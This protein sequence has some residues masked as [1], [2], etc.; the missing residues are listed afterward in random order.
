MRR[1]VSIVLAVMLILSI[2]V[3][4]NAESGL[5]YQGSITIAWQA[6]TD[7]ENVA[8]AKEEW[9][10]L[11]PGITI[12]FIDMM[13]NSD[14]T[15]WL[16][17]K[18]AGGMAPDIFWAQWSVVDAGIYPNGCAVS[19][20][21]YM[22]KPNIYVEGNEKWADLFYPSLYA[23]TSGATGNQ[24]CVVMDYVGTA[25]YYNK[26]MFEAAGINMA[27]YHEV[28]TWSDYLDICQ[29]LKD[30]GYTAWS[31]GFGNDTT[32]TL[33]TWLQR[34]ILTNLYADI[35]DDVCVTNHVQP[36]NVDNYIA[37]R[38]GLIGPESER[39]MS[40]WENMKYMVDNYMP[41]DCI[42]AACTFDSIFSQF[43]TGQLAMHWNSTGGPNSYAAANIDFEVGSFNFPVPDPD[44]FKYATDFD[45]SPA[46]GGPT[47]TYTYAISSKTAN[48]SMTDEKLEACV[49]FLMFVSAPEHCEGI[50]N[51]K[52]DTIPC[53]KG[54][55]PTEVNATLTTLVEA[56]VRAFHG[57]QESTTELT[58]STYRV[59]Q[60]YLRGNV[61]LEEAAETLKPIWEQEMETLYEDSI[62]ELVEPYLDRISE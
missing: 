10:K 20:N 42:S 29:K 43:V 39:W 51:E 40:W 53:V 21:E 7:L 60:D 23:R 33:R 15:T 12:E 4:A 46:V 25:V 47:G 24:Y 37:Y 2:S 27:D 6:P 61:T 31:F 59:F 5:S 19:L 57:G 52:G 38:N 18:M 9:E 54:A 48:A 28:V 44:S 8:A 50:V 30:A 62:S 1:L 41:E 32:C 16:K 45:S 3:V 56:E 14:Y 11:H 55:K 13:N 49:D 22:E 35:W 17:T 58:E 34:L 36:N 26:T